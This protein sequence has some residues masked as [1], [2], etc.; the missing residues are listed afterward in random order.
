VP[1]APA[2]AR[3]FYYGTFGPHMPDFD[4]HNPAVQAYHLDS[5]RIWLNRGLDGFRL[6]ATPHLFETSAK[7]WNDQPESRVFTKQLQDLIKS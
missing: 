4:F 6:D 5:L 1:P 2:E 7:D 3:G